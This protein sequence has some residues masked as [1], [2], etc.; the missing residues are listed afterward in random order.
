MKV[1]SRASSALLIILV[2]IVGGGDRLY[3]NESARSIYKQGQTAE[4]RQD[5]DKA[6]DAYRKAML[7]D[8]GDL[9]YKASCER[10]RLL[11]SAAHVK[12]G[13]E[14]RQIGQLRAAL[15]EFLRATAIDPSNMAAEQAIHSLANISYQPRK[16]P[17]YPSS[18]RPGGP[19]GTRWPNSTKANLRGVHNFTL[20]GG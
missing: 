4:A 3:A 6:F 7:Q 10:T 20:G 2:V 18:E 12:L 17:A 5:Y 16:R 8:P 9:G 19:G 11:A 15:V 1:S 14:L 13:N